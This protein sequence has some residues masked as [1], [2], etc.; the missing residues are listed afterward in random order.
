MRILFLAI[1]FPDIR[2]SSNIYT[3]LAEEF[4]S[5]GHEVFP[6]APLLNGSETTI[7]SE[8]NINVLRVKTFKLFK[9]NFILK[10]IANML[11]PF[12]YRR[13]IK[14]YYKDIIFDAV[15]L[16]TPPITLVSIARRYKKEGKKIYLILR[17]IF[18]Q[19]AVDLGIIQKWNPIYWIFRMKEKS[20]YKVSDYIGCM[21][22]GNINYII[23]HNPD[24]DSGKLHLL[25]NFQK[26]ERI[27]EGKKEIKSKLGLEDKFLVIFGGNMGIPQKLE[28]VVAL[29][30]ACQHYKDVVFL[31]I[32]DGNQLANIR[33]MIQTKKLNN[34]MLIPFLSHYE[35]QDLVSQCDIGLISLNEC[36]TIPNIPSKTL[37]YF[38]LGIPVLA[39][40][41]RNTDY[42]VILT[43][44]KAGLWSYAGEID[45]FKSNFDILYND[46]GLRKEMGLNGKKFFEENMTTEVAYNVIMTYLN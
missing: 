24:I 10:G 6:V 38:N 17:D 43:E 23:K 33:N 12:Q 16:P 15:I 32:G 44:A 27:T 40:I 45:C 25:H 21:S 36:F 18:P 46:A 14:K 5:K 42:G 2:K 7:V 35:Y 9:V 19:N 22:P 13:A 30:E 4:I 34:V 26:K 28:N 31:L 20:L 39:S 11:L 8:K 29:A 3:D 41:D 37:S 1:S